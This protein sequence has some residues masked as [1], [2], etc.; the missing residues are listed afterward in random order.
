MFKG[1][2]RKKAKE[3][4]GEKGLRQKN[5]GRESSGKSRRKTSQEEGVVH[6]A[7]YSNQGKKS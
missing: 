6:D 5:W 7:T 2:E 4:D 3:G 1:K